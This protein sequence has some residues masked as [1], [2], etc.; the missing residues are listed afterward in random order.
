MALYL[1]AG[2]LHVYA[3]TTVVTCHS[4]VL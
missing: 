2:V 3:Y 4:M 1:L